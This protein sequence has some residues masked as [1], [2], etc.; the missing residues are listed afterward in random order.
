MGDQGMFNVTC[1]GDWKLT[2]RLRLLLILVI[3]ALMVPPPITG[4]P[5]RVAN[6]MIPSWWS[7]ARQICSSSD[8]C[9]ADECCTRPMLS[10][11]FY[12]MPMRKRGQVCNPSPLLLNEKEELY[13]ND[14]PC[15]PQFSCALI[16]K[17]VHAS[18]VDPHE[19]EVDFRRYVT[20]LTPVSNFLNR[21]IP[22][23]R[24]SNLEGSILSPK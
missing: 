23:A 21:G 6:R 9:E 1:R 7:I 11:N 4:V 12:C 19:L 20:N 15:Q 22:A 14:C 16:N 13:F 3:T 10:L 24:K 17:E 18:C 8:D 5:K 2:R